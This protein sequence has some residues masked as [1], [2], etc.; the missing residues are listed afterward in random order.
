MDFELTQDQAMLHES[1]A[2]LLKDRYSFAARNTY[3]D[4]PNGWSPN[5]WA[6]YAGLGL[7]GLGIS[8]EDGGFGGDGVD[9]MI[10]MRAFGAALVME[11]YLSTVV[12]GGGILTASGSPAQRALLSTIVSGDLKLAFAHAE[13]RARYNLH[14]VETT[15]CRVDDGWVLDGEKIF[16]RHG[17]SAEKFI[18]SA[19]INGAA[20][21]AGGLAVFLIDADTPGLS[22]RS[23]RTQDRQHSDHVLLQ[24]LKVGDDALLGEPGKACSVIER[25]ADEA[26]AALCA[27]AVGCMEAAYGLTVA[28]LKTRQQFGVL[29]G[30]FQA[31][32]HRTADMLV[33]L[34]LA[35]SMMFEAAFMARHP[36]GVARHRA[37]AM[38]KIQIGRSGRFIGQQAIQLH[39]GIGTT[40]EYAAIAAT[41]DHHNALSTT[42][43]ETPERFA[44]IFL[45]DAKGA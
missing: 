21:D 40:E 23:L 10:V 32:Q 41:A 31:V 22:R 12:L 36:D 17:D 35:R 15:A 16:V 43:S 33:M 44:P 14:Y 30:S 9:H 8:E 42:L 39:G 27:E 24:N 1:I 5:L 28:Y 4:L 13:R 6:D 25:A 18:I 34:E 20:A 29:L 19:R 11:P 2:R 37:I 3:L 38:A 26:M 45:H 7:L